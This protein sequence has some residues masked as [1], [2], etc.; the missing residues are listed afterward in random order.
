MKSWKIVCFMS[1]MPFLVGCSSNIQ[2][3]GLS[4]ADVIA[5][6]LISPP[7]EDHPNLKAAE[8]ARARG[9]VPQSIR[10]YRDIIKQCP[11]CAKAYLG[12]GMAL[13]DANALNESKL[14]F[15]KAIALFPKCSEAYAGL[16]LVY[17]LID[18]PE[19]AI[20]SFDTALKLNPRNA[21]AYN[22]YGMA[23]DMVDEHETAQLNY[24]A[25]MELNPTN[26]SYESNLALS[27]ALCGN[28]TEAIHIL[29]RIVRSPDVTPRV[30]QNLALAYGLA[31]DMKMAKKIGRMDLPD[32]IV[33][34]NVNYF[35]SIQQTR[36][37]SG[38]VPK[39]NTTSLDGTRK[40][41]E[42]N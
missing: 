38:L 24:R 1:L 36:Q 32:D 16:G 18:Q 6:D 2:P 29:E 42:R 17:I 26:I 28:V 11:G 39:D 41:Q 5:S 40:W 20:N 33:M 10:D 34:N 14:T 31:G 12:L 35:E 4:M 13:I 37:Y 22:G 25:A 3:S 21:T 15:E 27:L 19:N 30:R 8:M 9:D 23:L 7:Y